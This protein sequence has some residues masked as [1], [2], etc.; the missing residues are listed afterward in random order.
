MKKKQ[1]RQLLLSQ[2]KNISLF[3]FCLCFTLLFVLLR[4]FG[5]TD[6]AANQM[7]IH[8]PI[9]EFICEFIL[10]TDLF[11]QRYYIESPGCVTE[12]NF[13]LFSKLGQLEQVVCC[14]KKTHNAY[15]NQ[16]TEK[17]VKFNQS[18]SQHFPDYFSTKT[19]PLL[20]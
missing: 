18:Q 3:V 1:K 7:R 10:Y 11:H 5:S 8:M 16:K 2:T 17:I 4:E 13:T 20:R 15:T 12:K 6:I 19:D 14:S 9:C